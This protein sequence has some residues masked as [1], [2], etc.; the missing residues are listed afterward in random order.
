MIDHILR[1]NRRMNDAI[2]KGIT[3][4]VNGTEQFRVMRIG[5]SA[6]LITSALG[7]GTKIIF[8]RFCTIAA[9]PQLGENSFDRSFPFSSQRCLVRLRQ[10]VLL[11]FTRQ[12]RCLS[13]LVPARQDTI[14]HSKQTP[15]T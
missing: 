15:L 6:R 10:L 2:S 12:I 5:H 13:I 14:A 3:T 1:D 11:Y 9:G 7:I 8:N 4:L